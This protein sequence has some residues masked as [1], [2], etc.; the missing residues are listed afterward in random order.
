MILVS[1]AID[2]V[3][4]L[5]QFTFFQL[6]ERALKEFGNDIDAAIKS[7]NEL[8][9]GSAQENLVAVVEPAANADEGIVMLDIN[10]KYFDLVLLYSTCAHQI[11][12]GGE[13]RISYF[14][15]CSYH[16]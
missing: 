2:C 6:L 4:I 14:Y 7:L 9:L 15:V 11:K 12:E 13:I 5:S 3:D 16:S 10:R 8:C 1:T